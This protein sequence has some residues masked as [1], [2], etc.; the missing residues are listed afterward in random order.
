MMLGQ[1]LKIK[2]MPSLMSYSLIPLGFITLQKNQNF[3]YKVE[4]ILKDHLQYLIRC[5]AKKVQ[6]IL[7]ESLCIEGMWIQ[8]VH[9]NDIMLFVS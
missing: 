7:V 2:S 6:D 8:Q 4:Y 1:K 5:Y 3:S 9:I